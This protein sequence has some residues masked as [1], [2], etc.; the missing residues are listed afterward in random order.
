MSTEDLEKDVRKI[1]AEKLLPVLIRKLIIAGMLDTAKLSEADYILSV[2]KSHPEFVKDLA[3]IVSI[4]DDFLE[5]ARDA[6]AVNRPEVAIILIATIVEHQLNMFYREALNEH[7]GLDDESI[8]KIIRSNSLSDKTSWLF[9]LVLRDEMDGNLQRKLLNLSELRNQI[10]HYKAA[11]ENIDDQ[12]SGSHNLIRAKVNELNFDEI[13]G[14]LTWL[15]TVL[16]DALSRLRLSTDD[17]KHTQE[18][19][20]ALQSV[21]QDYS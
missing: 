9:K 21:L 14:T 3:F 10:V 7:D 20:Q 16:E 11:P 17:Y 6:I 1:F 2:V 15:S 13:F 12:D 18:A 5:S 4:D 8:T 19:M